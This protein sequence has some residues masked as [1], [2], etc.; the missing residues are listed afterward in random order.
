[1]RQ[2]LLKRA[3]QARLKG[4]WAEPIS[5]HGLRAGFVTTAYRN[6][7]PTR[8]SWATRAIAVSRPCAAMSGGRS[9]S[10]LVQGRPHRQRSIGEKTLGKLPTILESL[11]KVISGDHDGSCFQSHDGPSEVPF[12]LHRKES[13]DVGLC[14]LECRARLGVEDPGDDSLFS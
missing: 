13:F 12:A 5:P 1:M 14:D 2:I 8:R 6:A 7:F 11:I 4:A 10:P 9:S 3:E